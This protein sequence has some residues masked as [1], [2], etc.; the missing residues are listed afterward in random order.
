MKN[1]HSD[2]VLNTYK[3]NKMQVSACLCGGVIYSL[4]TRGIGHISFNQF[5]GYLVLQFYL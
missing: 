5:Q 1:L 2:I 3:I 4:N